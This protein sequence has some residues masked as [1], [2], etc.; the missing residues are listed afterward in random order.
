MAQENIQISVPIIGTTPNPVAYA[1]QIKD[2]ETTQSDINAT[3]LR[4]TTDLKQNLY[5]LTDI[6]ALSLDNEHKTTQD[7]QAGTIFKEEIVSED[8][9]QPSSVLYYVAITDGEE[10]TSISEFGKFIF[11][12]NSV[13]A[14]HQSIQYSKVSFNDGQELTNLQKVQAQ[15]NIG[16]EKAVPNGVASLDEYGFIPQEQTLAVRFSDQLL[17]DSQQVQAQNNIEGKT[18]NPVMFSGL[19]KKILVKNIQ[20]VDDIQKNVMTQDFFDDDQE[21]HLTNTVFVI[22][23][24]YT[25][26]EDIEIGDGCTLEFDGGSINGAY[27]VTGNNTKLI[28]NI[29]FRDGVILSGTFEKS[30]IVYS[31]IFE[32]T[33]IGKVLFKNLSLIGYNIVLKDNSQFTVVKDSTE[34]EAVSISAENNATI[35]FT[36]GATIGKEGFVIKN[37][38]N[39]TLRNLTITED[40]DGASEAQH[41]T[42]CAFVVSLSQNNV[43]TNV[44]VDNC[45]FSGMFYS[46]AMAC[47]GCTNMEIR[48]SR[49]LNGTRFFDHW[50]YCSSKCKSYIA[51]NCKLENTRAWVGI[52]KARA[53]E[54]GSVTIENVICDDYRGYAVELDTIKN[55][56][57]D[58]VKSRFTVNSEETQNSLFGLISVVSGATTEEADRIAARDI[59]VNSITIRDSYIHQGSIPTNNLFKVNGTCV[60][61]DISLTI[62]SSEVYTLGFL[63][64]GTVNVN[65]SN[66]YLQGKQYLMWDVSFFAKNSKIHNKYYGSYSI[67]RLYDGNIRTI[68]LDACEIDGSSNRYLIYGNQ[69]SGSAPIIMI[70]RNC[71]LSVPYGLIGSVND[72]FHYTLTDENNSIQAGGDVFGAK[73]PLNAKSGNAAKR[74]E[75]VINGGVLSS[76]DIGYRYYDT[77]LGKPVYMKGIDANDNVI[78]ADGQGIVSEGEMKLTMVSENFVDDGLVYNNETHKF[79]ASNDDWKADIIDVQNYTNGVITVD[80]GSKSHT[81]I[82]LLNSAPVLND[83]MDLVATISTSGSYDIGSAKYLLVLMLYSG[84]DCTPDNLTITTY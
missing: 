14:I 80:F 68:N 37:N 74:P 44:L 76:S 46:S 53:M 52:F 4:D 42:G 78:W 81:S 13:M 8:V 77:T 1:N 38:D 31:D 50:I 12:P 34:I 7:Y 3:L 2:G 64:S 70:I 32:G 35:N 5:G 59:Y 55:T 56:K 39:F 54:R 69:K 9:S 11:C 62:D 16:L 63:D 33:Y 21:E 30:D 65:N 71:K 79:V 15:K 43:K 60:Y 20:L 23:Y 57:V 66:I 47:S 48:N 72:N 84:G 58:I 49:C 73:T 24:D 36:Q 28:G 27:T 19:G 41:T 61:D 75:S 51:R 6:P 17:T 83:D 45:T 67:F 29:S 26:T 18:Y 10:G 40:Y 25:L 82:F 22:K